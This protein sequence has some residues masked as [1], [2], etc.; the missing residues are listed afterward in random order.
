ME[1]FNKVLLD[2]FLTIRGGGTMKTVISQVC[3]LLIGLSYLCWTCSLAE[4]VY[5]SE[6][7]K[8]R[9]MTPEELKTLGPGFGCETH[10]ENAG[11]NCDTVGPCCFLSAEVD[12]EFQPAKERCGSTDC[13]WFW[14]PCDTECV[15]DPQADC[16]REKV[17]S[18]EPARCEQSSFGV[19]GGAK[20]FQYYLGN[21]TDVFQCHTGSI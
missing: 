3:A 5:A 13:G 14:D 8:A 4:M 12:C 15:E 19:F 11:E 17:Y 6:K 2:I 7:A 1:K 20:T 10:C 9:D 18:C 21:C 16:G